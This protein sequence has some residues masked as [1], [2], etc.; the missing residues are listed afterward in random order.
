MFQVSARPLAAE[1]VSSIEI[2]ILVLQGFNED[3]KA[4]TRL[5]CMVR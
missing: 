4:N 1:A 5:P 2:E 3:K